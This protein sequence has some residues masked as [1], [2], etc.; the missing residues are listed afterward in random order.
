MG[1]RESGEPF[2]AGKLF[3]RSGMHI[4]LW[5]KRDGWDRSGW[6]G[7]WGSGF[8]GGGATGILLRV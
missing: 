4:K 7:A 6:R 5:R 2:L 8:A 3:K 1:R